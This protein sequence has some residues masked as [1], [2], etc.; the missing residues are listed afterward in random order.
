[1]DGILDEIPIKTLVGAKVELRRLCPEDSK[2]LYQ[3]IAQSRDHLAEFLP[4]PTDCDSP[5]D[6]ESRL[7]TWDMQAQMGNG[8]CWGVFERGTEGPE[9][10]GCIFIGW[11]HP[12]HR[13]ATVSYWLFLP[14]VGR[15]LATEALELLSRYCFGELGLNRLEITA[16]VENAKS[17]AV[18]T[19]AG[20]SKEGVCREFECLRGKFLDHLRF[21]RLAGDV[22]T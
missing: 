7:E 21:S 11:I 16:A 3:K 20:F 10:A 1:M 8:G 19:R 4:W 14:Y 15:G 13:S 6:V 9:L 2:E 17:I 5:E 22:V 18:A 12:E